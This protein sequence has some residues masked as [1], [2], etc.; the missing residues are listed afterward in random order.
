VACVLAI[1]AI[2]KHDFLGNDSDMLTVKTESG[3]GMQATAQGTVEEI[4][5][6]GGAQVMSLLVIR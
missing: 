3:G 4:K 6:A 1:R 5:T 2:L